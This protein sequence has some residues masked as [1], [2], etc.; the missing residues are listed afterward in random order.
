MV[1]GQGAHSVTIKYLKNIKFCLYAGIKTT[2]IVSIHRK[3]I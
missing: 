2:K 1:L 3:M